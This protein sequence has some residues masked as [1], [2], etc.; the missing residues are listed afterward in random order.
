[1]NNC[2]TCGTLGWVQASID[3]EGSSIDPSQRA[4]PVNSARNQHLLRLEE[5]NSAVTQI[6]VNE[7]LSLCGPVSN[8]SS[9][10]GASQGEYFSYR[11]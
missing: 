9:L 4:S 7:V 10:L 11:E 1:M 2:S 3:S 5:Q 8:G 6:E